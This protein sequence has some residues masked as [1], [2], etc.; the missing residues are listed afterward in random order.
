MNIGPFGLWYLVLLLPA[1]V[2]L[3]VWYYRRT[4]PDVTARSRRLL[5]ALRL[6]V[7]VAVAFAL[8]R[9]VF[10]WEHQSTRSPVWLR[11]IDYSSSMDRQDGPGGN[12]TRL[13]FARAFLQSPAWSKVSPDV[14]LETAFFA[15]SSAVDTIGLGREGTDLAAALQDYS[16]IPNPPSAVF[17][18]SD[19]AI[20]SASDPSSSTWPFP[21]YTICV[22][23][24]GLAEDRALVGIDA[25]AVAIAGDSVTV[26]VRATSSGD[27]G[28]GII[29]FQA[30]SVTENR[31]LQ[32]DGANRQQEVVFT[33]RPDTAGIY[34]VSV[35]I[36]ASTQEVAT[37]NNRIETRIY[38]E[39]R[40]Q[41]A[42]L[43]AVAPD[44]ESSFLSRRLS[45]LDRLDLDVRYRSMAGKGGFTPWPESFD[46]LAAF[47][48]IILT[49]MKAVDWLGLS[50]LLDRYQRERSGGLLFLLGPQA[51]SAKWSKLQTE[52]CML[53]FAAHPPG[54]VSVSDPAR[55]TPAGRYHPVGTL[56]LKEAADAVWADLPFLSGV[57]PGLPAAGSVALA[58]I[59]AGGPSWPAVIA[60][61]RNRG[62]VLV[63][64]GYPL[65]RWDFA[66]AATPD[67]S[68]WARPF[69]S[70]AV[71]W[72]TSGHQGERL[73][74]EVLADP[75][76][77]LSPPELS[78]LLVDESWQPETRAS[79]MAE[80]RD[81]DGSLVQ[82]FEMRP[83]GAGRYRGRGRPLDPGD[84]TYVV[85][86]YT[87]T[88]KV[89]ETEGRLSAS[90]VS[91]EALSP[92]S[93]PGILEN[94]AVASG[95]KRLSI[96]SWDAILDSLTIAPVSEI[97]QSSLRIWESPWLM[98]LILLMLCLEWIMR[99]RF[100][101]L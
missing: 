8:A 51:A 42:L 23:D 72:L 82:T 7:L 40:K 17:V 86:A 16:R 45:D 73:T 27:P 44:W 15:D 55:M 47:D 100:Q 36:A 24:S 69:W 64:L 95:A 48:V 34:N 77:A 63:T 37:A 54:V 68:E 53:T 97:R 94:L 85:R 81:V 67:K 4:V 46:S 13:E 89:A 93:R 38:V 92:A 56:G 66:L 28:V 21:V 5:L 58:E 29:Q 3:S 9:P 26:R 62:R 101:M 96:E 30:G 98:G 75:V 20:N 57:V 71:R 14:K 70:A 88:L 43:L 78:A 61:H 59:P 19:G 22:G 35:E 80:I 41:R 84:Y 18:V 76:P 1:L 10:E 11:L 65:W 79:L 2:L 83:S 32:L 12:D 90:S 91:R 50:S 33:F 99:R 6:V 52:I 60:G 25:P 31:S 74:V 39:P 87:D 49:D